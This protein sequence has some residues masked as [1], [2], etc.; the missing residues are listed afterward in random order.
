LRRRAKVVLERE[1]V[2]KCEKIGGFDAVLMAQGLQR[3][4]EGIQ[5]IGA[6][7]GDLIRM[8]AEPLDHIEIDA[9]TDGFPKTI[10]WRIESVV[11]VTEK[12][13]EHRQNA[14]ATPGIAGILRVR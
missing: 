14:G 1:I 4:A 13:T 11:D 7:Q 6:P 5:I 9:V 12:K 3:C 2:H 8:I 10:V